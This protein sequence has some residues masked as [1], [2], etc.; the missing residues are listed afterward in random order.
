MLEDGRSGGG[1]KLRTFCINIQRPRNVG[2]QWRANNDKVKYPIQVGDAQTEN[3][4][5]G[6]E[7]HFE[8]V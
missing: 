1:L 6:G 2:K 7:R 4:K 3:V 5:R 8:N